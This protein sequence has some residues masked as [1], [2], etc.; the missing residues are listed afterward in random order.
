MNTY[1][2][3]QDSL[4]FRAVGIGQGDTIQ[5]S[6]CTPFLQKN[7]IHIWSARY[8]DLDRHY[9]VLSSVIT[10]KEHKKAFTFRKSA[11]TRRYILRH[12]M[13][14]T[15]LSNYTHHEPELLR[16]LTNKNGKP[17]LDPQCGY[18][19]V[20]FNLSHTSDM[21]LIGVARMHRIGVDVVKMDPHYPYDTIAGYMF[22]PAEKAFMQSTEPDLRCQIF[23]RIWALKEALLKA[24]GGTVMMMKDTD[25]SEIMQETFP[26]CCCAMKPQN[27]RSGFFIYRFDSGHRHHSVIAAGVREQ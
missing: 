18:S 24:T 20:S 23:F 13:V 27:I 3:L 15:I 14:R 8:V 2:R 26:S 6:G 5:E 7:T 1:K 10:P 22:T 11:D 9:Q 17:E 25:V 19:D 21:V 12:G 16:L 4:D